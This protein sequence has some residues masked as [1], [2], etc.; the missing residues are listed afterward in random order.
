MSVKASFQ[1]DPRLSAFNPSCL[2]KGRHA[3]IHRIF[4]TAPL[5]IYDAF[6]VAPTQRRV[7]W[8]GPTDGLELSMACAAISAQAEVTCAESVQKAVSGGAIAGADF[9]ILA[10]DRPGRFTLADSL[11]L[12]Q[13]WPLLPIVSVVSSLVDGRRRSG[14]AFP[15]IEEVPWH[16]LAGRCGWW[17]AS[18]EAGLPTSLGLPATARREERL[19][20]SIG[21]IRRRTAA[22]GAA[23]NVAVAAGRAVDLEGLCDLLTLTG[24]RVVERH[25]GR[26]DLGASA[27]ALIWDVG[28]LNPDALAWLGLL[29]ANRPGLF[30]VLLDSFP[31]GDTSQA[32]VRAG[33]AAVLG[34][35]LSLETLAGTLLRRAWHP[36]WGRAARSSPADHALHAGLGRSGPTR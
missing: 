22:P 5:T 35:P 23:I 28:D 13:A 16:E 12:S 36:S 31:R 10:A 19:L 34:R 30:I 3:T 27:P 1:N 24:H 17:L 21:D 33:A 2:R 6:P 7:L 32:A 9:G 4:M 14:P 11:L 8:I 29:A 15:G 20:E 18:L 26:P 25:H